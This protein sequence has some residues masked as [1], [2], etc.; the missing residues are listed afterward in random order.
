MLKNV[1][2]SFSLWLIWIGGFIRW[3]VEFEW[4]PNEGKFGVGWKSQNVYTLNVVDYVVVLNEFV[5]NR[6]LNINIF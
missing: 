1:K 6:F 4:S 2:G 5:S 3:Q